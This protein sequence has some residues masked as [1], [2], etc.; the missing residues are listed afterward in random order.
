MARALLAQ[1][2]IC[3]AESDSIHSAVLGKDPAAASAAADTLSHGPEQKQ[4][5][6]PCF[7]QLGDAISKGYSY[8]FVT[9]VG[10]GKKAFFCTDPLHPPTSRLDKNTIGHPELEFKYPVTNV[11]VTL[12]EPG[13]LAEAQ[14]GKKKAK[15]VPPA[16]EAAIRAA[17]KSPAEEAAKAKANGVYWDAIFAVNRPV[18]IIG[19]YDPVED[20]DTPLL[21]AFC[22][23]VGDKTRLELHVTANGLGDGSRIK[24]NVDQV[25]LY[26][27]R[28]SETGAEEGC[29]LGETVGKTKDLG[30]KLGGCIAGDPGYIPL[31]PPKRPH[32]MQAHTPLASVLLALFSVA[33]ARGRRRAYQRF[34]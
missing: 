5:V 26:E 28:L 33:E 6:V 32:V 11:H 25:R 8:N 12:A 34:L 15:K 31:P 13:A 14:G 24:K 2:A 3:R 7:R 1:D 21:K 18:K 23:Q 10:L 20:G 29:G 27:F 22:P 16:A 9:H 4:K 17:T 30:C 19:R